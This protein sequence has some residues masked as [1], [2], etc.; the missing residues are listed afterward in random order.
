M[1]HS[2]LAQVVSALNLYMDRD[3]YQ[4]DIASNKFK[5]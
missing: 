3:N 1:S 2:Y 5:N 4:N